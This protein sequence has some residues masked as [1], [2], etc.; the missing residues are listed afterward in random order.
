MYLVSNET[1]SGMKNVHDSFNNEFVFDVFVSLGTGQSMLTGYRNDVTIWT[2]NTGWPSFILLGF[3]TFC[4]K[5]LQAR[6]ILALCMW[7]RWKI[8]AFLHFNVRDL[9]ERKQRTNRGCSTKEWLNIFTNFHIHLFNTR[10]KKKALLLG[11]SRVHFAK[12]V[13]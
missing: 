9:I 3:Y 2:H 6:R 11:W 5:N 13:G 8:S 1:H 4:R 10:A 7:F 12:I